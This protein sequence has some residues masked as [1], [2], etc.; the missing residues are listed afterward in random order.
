MLLTTL[1]LAATLK[2]DC[3]PFIES[4]Q[5]LLSSQP[6]WQAVNRDEMGTRNMSLSHRLDKLGLFDGNPDDRAQLKP[7]NGDHDEI[8][9]WTL[10]RDNRRPFYLVCHYQNSVI[11]LQ[12]ALPRGIRDCRVNITDRHQLHGLICRK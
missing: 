3:P 12:Q 2:I 1:T 9:Y 11:T 7:D 8:H 4:R 6:E 10:D 5:Q